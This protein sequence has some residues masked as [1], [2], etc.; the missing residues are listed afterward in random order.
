MW[1]RGPRGGG[2]RGRTLIT[3]DTDCWGHQKL[4]EAR[5]DLAGRWPHQHLGFGLGLLG[6]EAPLSSRHFVLVF[7]D[8]GRLAQC[9]RGPELASSSEERAV[10]LWP[11]PGWAPTSGPSVRAGPLS[12]PFPGGSVTP[13]TPWRKCEW[14]GPRRH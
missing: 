8:H 12:L 1:R 5:R 10:H 14:Q 4:A 7:Q 11:P 13:A 2:G 3:G 6:P 9:P